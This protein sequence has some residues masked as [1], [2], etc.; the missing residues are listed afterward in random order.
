MVFRRIR[1]YS[2]LVMFEHTLFA[3]PY[4]LSAVFMAS[5]GRPSL[6][7]LF[8]VTAAMVGARNGANALNRVVD[9]D[10][11]AKNRRTSGRHI[12]AGIVKKREAV[13]LAAACFLL[14]LLAAYELNPVCFV[15]IPVPIA[16]FILYSYTKRFT[17]M[18]HIILGI[19]IGGAPVGA[20][21]GVTGRIDISLLPSF[22]IGA[23][24]ALWIAGFDII[25]GTQDI[26]FDR[27]NGLHSIPERF[28]IPGA[29]RISTLFHVVSTLL[30]F[31][32]PQFVSLGVLY[33][34]G[35]IIV[36][37]LLFYEHMIVSPKH[38][39]SVKIASYSVNQIIGVVFLVFSISD[40]LLRW[41]L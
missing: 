29:L 30:L 14:F 3:L 36:S 1:I 35:M 21:L 16:L 18:C 23:A 24:V 31:I 4:A 28:G 33:Y 26:E 8:W 9:A 2:D 5:G 19:S 13:A 20:W 22:I 6:G 34:T 27:Q 32:L 15:L 10:I 7:K 12:P 37:G 38:L 25:Y 11:D 39:Q 41:Y 17:W 40:M